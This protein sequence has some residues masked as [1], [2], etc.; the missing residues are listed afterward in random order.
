MM[1]RRISTYKYIFYA[2][3][4]ISGKL[5]RTLFAHGGWRKV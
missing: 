2:R 3:G 5:P 4:M 1:V